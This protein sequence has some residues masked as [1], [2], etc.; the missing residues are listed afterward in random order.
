[1]KVMRERRS[2]GSGGQERAHAPAQT[3]SPGKLTRVDAIPTASDHGAATPPGGVVQRSADSDATVHGEPAAIARQATAGPGGKLPH[4]DRVQSLF[5][6]HD[7]SHVRSHEGGAAAAGAA[8]LGARAFAVDDAVAF[9]TS[10]DLHTAAHEAAHVVQQAAGVR[11]AGGIDQPGD[12]YERHADRVADAVVA[13]RSAEPLL[14]ELA[15]GARVATSAPAVQRVPDPFVVALETKLKAANL[16]GFYGDIAGLNAARAGDAVLRTAFTTFVGA[17]HL[18]WKQAFRAVAFQE[19]GPEPAWPLPVKNFAEGVDRGTYPVA[20]LPPKG[21]DALREHCVK[22]AGTAADGAADLRTQYR[23]DFNARFD[24][25]R[26]AAL[27]N[28]LDPTK[29]SKGPRTARAREIFKE[30]YAMPVY[31][32]AYDSDVPAGFREQADTFV[33]PDGTNQIASLRLQEL[34]ATLSG[35]VVLA[36]NTADPA[37]V[38]LVAAVRPNARSSTACTSG[39]SRSMPKCKARPMPTPMRCERTCGASRPRAAR[40]PRRVPRALWPPLL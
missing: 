35:P 6:R 4:F 10:P 19:Y 27:T 5:G 1:V 26:F 23:T 36:A 2:G 11:P 30:L 38:A 28:N 24:S 32:G 3:P 14:D 33:G 31:K 16:A 21:A 13:G 18:T 25:S 40:P 12:E 9:G 15:G 17:G 20:A 8:Q 34:R 37:Y 29:D 39:A 7:I 22:T